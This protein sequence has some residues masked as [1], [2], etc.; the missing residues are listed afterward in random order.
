MT[1]RHNMIKKDEEELLA[2]AGRLYRVGPE[3]HFKDEE[4]VNS[5]ISRIR[6]TT[7]ETVKRRTPLVDTAKKER[8]GTLCCVELD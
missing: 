3:R 2:Y 6:E 4:P 7:L 5:E 8:G 1:T